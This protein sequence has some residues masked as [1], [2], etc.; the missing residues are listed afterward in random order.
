MALGISIL[1]GII[2]ALGASGNEQPWSTGPIPVKEQLNFEID[3]FLFRDQKEEIT[4]INPAY[5]SDYEADDDDSIEPARTPFETPTMITPTYV[6][7]A[8]IQ[9]AS[10]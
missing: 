8:Y 2:Y 9:S 3:Q 6:R 1:G 4:G 10:E 5:E 7:R